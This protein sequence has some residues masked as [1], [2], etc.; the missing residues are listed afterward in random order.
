[1]AVT[2]PIYMDHQATTPVAS[3]VFE[4]MRP[5]FCERFGNPASRNHP[6]G[7]VAEE[8]VE[9]ARAQVAHLLG[10]KAAEIVWTSGATEANNLAIKG[11]AAAYREKG[12]HIITSRTEHHAVLDTCRRLEHEGCQVTYLPVDKTGRVDPGDV[13]RAIRKDTVLI[14]I[15][16]ANNEIGTLQPVAEIGR[17]AKRH[18]VLF[19]T[20]AA[21]YVGKLPLSVDD[22]QVDLL[23]ASAHKCYGPKGVGA[24]YVRMTKP[25]VK[26]VPQM[27]GGGHEKGRR[28]GTL[29]VPGCVGFGAACALAERE[30]QTEPARLLS[31]RERLRNDLW[32]GLDYLHLNGHP[33]ERLPGN[34]NISFRFVE[35][36][37]LLMALKGIAVSSGSACTSATVEPSYVLLAIGLNAELAHASIR[38]GLGRSNTE[39]E[40]D[41]VAARVIENV[42]RLRALSPLYEMAL[43]GIDVKD[44]QWSLRTC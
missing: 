39:E 44:T 37:S 35:G 6:F 41:Y 5:Y 32:S 10:C 29:N 11:V 21:Q 2:L 36:E 27:D 9:Q 42:T 15:M 28:S 30:L 23:S 18:G 4:A 14:S 43:E 31:L 3:E 26:L 40:V 24:L 22:W 13:E 20:D 33:T 16:A 25:R 1:M 12:R 38:F 7:W 19:H 8:A 34:L 17:I